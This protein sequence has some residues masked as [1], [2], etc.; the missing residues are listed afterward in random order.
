[1]VITNLSIT[2]FEIYNVSAIL[3]SANFVSSNSGLGS[4]F[5]K[6]LIKSLYILKTK[7]SRG[8][9]LC[10]DN[11]NFS[12]FDNI[13]KDKLHRISR[14]ECHKWLFGPET[15]SRLLRNGPLGLKKPSHSQ[16][17]KTSTIVITIINFDYP[18]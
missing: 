5:Q 13:R 9:K 11:K 4:V 6:G 8:T 15:F 12:S 2:S 1:M 7:A 18:P 3:V 10:S 17:Q 16:K 14:P